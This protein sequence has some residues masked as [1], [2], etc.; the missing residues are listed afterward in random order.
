MHTILNLSEHLKYW[1][2]TIKIYEDS[3]PEWEREAKETIFQRLESK[4][5]LG[6][7]YT[8]NSEVVAFAILDVNMTLN[9]ILFSFLAVRKNQRGV[10]LG[11]KLSLYVIEY[12]KRKY[13]ASWL[14]I[15]A[16]ERQALLYERIGFKRLQLEYR[17]PKFHSL[18]SVPM[19]LMIITKKPLDNDMP[20]KII[21]DI[22][23]RGYSLDLDD[24]RIKQQLQ[25]I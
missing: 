14:L 21:K 2:A 9:Y 12:C 11:L 19:S 8:I 3:F 25:R 24:I 7:I 10:G 6:F 1:D 22:F 17:V 20:S 4:E 18:E 13:T 23:H 15:E 16:E 5:Y